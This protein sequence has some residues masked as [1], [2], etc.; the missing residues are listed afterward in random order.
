VDAWGKPTSPPPSDREQ[1]ARM[2][3]DGVKRLIERRMPKSR[4]ELRL[5]AVVECYSGTSAAHEAGKIL[6]R[7]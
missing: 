4:V 3:L 1:L 2:L 5:R 7:Q 6:L